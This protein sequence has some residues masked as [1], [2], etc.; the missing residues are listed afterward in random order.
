M[1]QSDSLK[2][3]PHSKIK[4]APKRAVY[5]RQQI[6]QIIDQALVAYLGFNMNG[7][8]F[9]LPTSTWRDENKIYWHGAA[10][11]RMTRGLLE[12]NICI[13]LALLDGLVLARSAFHHSVNYRSVN[14]FGQPN[15]V[16][17]PAEKEQQLKNFIEHLFPNRWQELRPMKDN[18]LKATAVMS[19]T[20]D[21][22]SAKVRQGGP[23]DDK[24]DY[25]WPT[26]AGVIPV[27]TQ[28]GDAQP[29]TQLKADNHDIPS[30]NSVLAK[31]R[32]K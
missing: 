12:Q 32:V 3:T 6:Y 11:G 23:L 15:L 19:L 13:S 27:H 21:E 9:V 30:P 20:I 2:I 29:C 14:L 22:G 10:S 31:N 24:E 28:W 5:D 17:D 26:W 1:L 18:E 7:Q 25:Q 4:R 8:P 16:T